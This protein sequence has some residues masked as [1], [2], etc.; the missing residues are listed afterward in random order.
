MTPLSFYTDD[1]KNASMRPRECSI[2]IKTIRMHY[3]VHALR[4]ARIYHSTC[5]ALAP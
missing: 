3:A 4:G 5:T 1:L 2:P